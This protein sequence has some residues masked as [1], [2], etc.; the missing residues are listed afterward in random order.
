MAAAVN[1]AVGWGKLGSARAECLVEWVEEVVRPAGWS[2]VWMP[3]ER[4]GG[5]GRDR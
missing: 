5:R 1:E 2:K 4:P 3:P